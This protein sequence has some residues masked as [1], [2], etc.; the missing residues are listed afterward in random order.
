MKT[1]KIAAVLSLLGSFAAPGLFAQA[2]PE[3]TADAASPAVTAPAADPFDAAAAK[4]GSEDPMVRRQ[5]I[6][7]LAQRRDPKAAPVL[8]KALADSSSHVRQAA[9]EGLGLL[10]WSAAAPEISALL[11]DD[12]DAGVR[13]QAAISLSYIRDPQA[14]PAL[15]KALADESPA[16]RYAAMRTLGTM[17]YVPA[18]GAIADMLSGTDTNML[19][20][21]ISALGM[22]QSTKAVSAVISALG[23]QDLY[24]RVEAAR[25]LGGIGD[26]SAQPELK[27]HLADAEAALM[28]VESALALSKMGFND[29]LPTAQEFMASSDL[30]LRSQALSVIV[31]LG[32]V[33]S[34]ARIE[35]LY[36]AEK[37]PAA[38]D[39]L[40][41]ARQRL[42]DIQ[43]A[44]Q[45]K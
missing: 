17:K 2:A 8:V 3:T 31:S 16:V 12:A 35:E 34:L 29:G 43:A 39:M 36:A 20:S 40:D 10:A 13:Q 9:V 37:D 14:G 25:A 11:T 24:M 23:H 27:N 7:L 18:D 33:G 26:K 44:Q 4:V 45:K 19:R 32:D 38:K 6:N 21:A 1:L 28:R 41:Y 22:I 5:G 15:V 30:S 42:L